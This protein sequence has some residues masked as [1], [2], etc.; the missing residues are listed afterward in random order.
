[1]FRALEGVLVL[2]TRPEYDELPRGFGVW[3][4]DLGQQLSK[5]P[6]K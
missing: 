3:P 4:E 1:M 5:S 6:F 2:R